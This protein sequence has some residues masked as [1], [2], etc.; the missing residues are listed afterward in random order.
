[1]DT[2]VGDEDLT[3]NQ[4]ATFAEEPSVP[5]DPPVLYCIW[6]CVTRPRGVSRGRG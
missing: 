5:S 2:D 1:M 4:V 3:I 6:R